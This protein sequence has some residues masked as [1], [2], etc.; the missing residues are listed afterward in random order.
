[1]VIASEGGDATLAPTC[2]QEDRIV[3][4]LRKRFGHVSAEWVISGSGLENIDQAIAALEGSELPPR[5]A[6]EITKNALSGE[7][8][9]ARRSLRAF[10]AF[11]GI[12]QH[13]GPELTGRAAC[14]AKMRSTLSRVGPPR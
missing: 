14:P 3:N 11:F 9:L 2:E 7:W 4:H 13:D 8:Q 10:C 12:L 1:M 5:S 6:A